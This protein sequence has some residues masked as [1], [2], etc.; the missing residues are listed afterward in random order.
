MKPVAKGV[1]IMAEQIS[2]ENAELIGRPVIENIID[3]HV[4]ADYDRLVELIPGMKGQLSTEEFN[5]AVSKLSPMGKVVSIEYI[6]HLNK[7][8]EHLLLW[9]VSYD[10]GEEEILWHLYL[11][12]T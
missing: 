9:K 6:G 11:S 1:D 8:K 3:A 2:N 7:V 10:L 5:E 12:D 4:N